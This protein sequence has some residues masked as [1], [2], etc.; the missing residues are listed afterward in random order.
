M[1]ENTHI[2]QQDLS[3]Y[4]MH[5]L[6]PDEQAAVRAHLSGCDSCRAELAAIMGDLAL[7][8]MS[9]EQHPLPEGA[10]QRFLNRI[11]TDRIG[12]EDIGAAPITPPRKI[13]NRA[14]R[15][16]GFHGQPLPLYC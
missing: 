13:R 6:A 2:P 5:A 14:A 9:V 3:L 10:R 1:N 8:A 4:A 15:Q 11:G 7:V 16:R 12:A